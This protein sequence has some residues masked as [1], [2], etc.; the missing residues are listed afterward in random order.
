MHPSLLK[1]LSA[2]IRRFG[3]WLAEE[4]FFFGKLVGSSA[5]GI[6]AIVLLGVIFLTSTHEKVPLDQLRGTALETLRIASRMESDINVMENSHRD[7]LAS[8]ETPF[9]IQFDTAHTALEGRL[10][11]LRSI[12]AKGSPESDELTL[13][14]EKLKM[15]GTDYAAPHLQARLKGL[16]ASSLTP[17]TQA[18]TWLDSARV[19]L[20]KFRQIG[21]ETLEKA[22]HRATLQIGGFSALCIVAIGFLIASSWYSLDV[23]R[24]HLRKI[25]TAEAQTRAIVDSTRDGVITVDAAGAIHSVNPAAQ[26]LFAQTSAQIVGRNIAAL[27]PD[28]LVD[29]DLPELVEVTVTTVGHRN[30]APPFPIEVSLSDMH[31]EGTKRFALVVRDIAER[32]R[33]EETLRHIGMGLSAATGEEFLKSLVQELS[34]ALRTEYGFIIELHRKSERLTSTLT[35]AE[36]GHM[37]SCG[38]FEISG[39]ACGDVLQSGFRAYIG[40]ARARF[41]D[42]GLLEGLGVD[43]FVA[44]PL[45]DHRGQPV[46]VMGVLDHR[47]LEAVQVIESTLQIFAA[48]AGAEIERKRFDEDL[49]AEKERLAVTLRSIGDGFITTDNSGRVLMLNNVAERLTG[50]SQEHA[51]GLPLTDVFRLRHDRTRRP[52][53]DSIMTIVAEG[54]A[55]VLAGPTVIVAH[56]GSE[57]MIETNASPIKDGLNEK[58][59]V[60]LVFR[61]VTERMRSEEERRKNEKL[62]S[63]GVAAGGIAHDFNNLLTAILGNV[64][65]ALM[66]GKTGDPITDRL[67]A[68]KKASLRAQEL[69]RQLLTFAKGGAP[70]KKTASIAQLVRDTVGFSLRGSNVRCEFT[71]PGDLWPADVDPGQISQVIQNLAINADQAMPAGGTMRV[72]CGN[73]ELTTEHA[74]LRLKPGRYLRITVRDEGIG[75]PEDNLKKI[76]DPYFTTKPKGSGLGLATTYSIIKN[77]GGIVDVVSQPSE[78]TTFY[79]FLPASDKPVVVEEAPAA[80]APLPVH[81]GRILVLDDEDAICALVTCALEPLGYA[82]TE[83]YDSLQAIKLYEDAITAGRRFDLVISDLTIPG[84]MGGLEALKRLREIDPDVKA[85]V[86]SGYAM[87]PIMSDFRKHGFCG[88]IAKPYEIDALGR[89]VATALAESRRSDENVI[90]VDFAEPK[91]GAA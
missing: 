63:L 5:A 80:E 35:L 89:A 51:T 91:S 20:Q 56:D 41:P 86:S 64:S 6:L 67:V 27:I 3:H 23:F 15:W 14:S 18:K 62:E 32:K 70:I 26:R 54:S 61:D 2:A 9:R 49:S 36:K 31:F 40:G 17:F 22:N 1:Q 57:R 7:F 43:T 65:I 53:N 25:E 13:I 87:D 55:D 71:I 59:G 69:A 66:H 42:D 76:F 44:M 48:R 47:K 79:I 75:I 52:L 85:I 34:R 12:V 11:S 77:H 21:A 16:N 68:A 82:V 50:W 29:G 81:G 88:M 37:L 46:G 83:A 78:G 8:G 58:V 72:D 90:A 60:V 28:L 45:L 84:G 39:S 10:E 33:G 19:G 73:V 74:R 38:Q 4:N 24:T 30:G